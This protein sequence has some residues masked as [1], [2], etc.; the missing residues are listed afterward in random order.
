[1]IVQLAVPAVMAMP[2]SPES[3]PVPALNA[4]VAGPEQPAEYATAGVA[5]LR[6]RPEGSVSPI[7]MPPCAGL[8]PVLVSVK[9]S[10]VASAVGDR[11]GAEGLGDGGCRRP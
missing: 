4:A 6:R 10:V 2:V 9:T 1:M 8:A 11:G 5:E 7:A 3:T